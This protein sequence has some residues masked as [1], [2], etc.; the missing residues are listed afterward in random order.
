[1]SYGSVFSPGWGGVTSVANAT[2]AT[3]AVVLPANAQEA[4][5]TNT[6][7]TA[8]TYVLVTTYTGVTAPTGNAPTA[9]TGF[10]V[11][12]NTTIRL[13]VG[14]GPKVIRTIASAADGNIIIA[15]GNGV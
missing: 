12:P 4:A 11:L 2:S 3:A 10:P 5:L 7:A 14:Q 6:S 8:I 15:P 13:H 9:S 1:M